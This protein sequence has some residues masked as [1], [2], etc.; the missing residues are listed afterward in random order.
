MPDRVGSPHLQQRSG[1]P[2]GL[3]PTSWSGWSRFQQS[4][5][6]GCVHVIRLSVP[7]RRSPRSDERGLRWVMAATRTCWLTTRRL[8]LHRRMG[9]RSVGV[10]G[11]VEQVPALNG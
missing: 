1:G 9:V 6:S 7:R 11:M 10:F 2:T 8:Y 4:A 5:H 3:L